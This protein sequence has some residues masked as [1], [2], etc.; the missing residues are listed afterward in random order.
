MSAMTLWD[1]AQIIMQDNQEHARN[2]PHRVH[3][4]H[5]SV[6]MSRR[7]R[8]ILTLIVEEK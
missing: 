7:D 3:A 8:C 5:P 4:P 2:H 6:P 1:Y